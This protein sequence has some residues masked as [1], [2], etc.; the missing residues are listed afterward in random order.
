MTIDE[1]RRELVRVAQQ[2]TLPAVVE[3]F[4]L[5]YTEQGGGVL[6]FV[7]G[8]TENTNKH[9]RNPVRFQGISYQPLPIEV[10]GFAL[11]SKGELPRPTL[12]VSNVPFV[13]VSGQGEPV[14]AR[15]FTSLVLNF[16][17]LVGAKLIRRRTF[18]PY[19]DTQPTA[20][21]NI[22]F[23]EDVYFVEQKTV[24]NRNIVEFE[25]VTSLDLDGVQLPRRQVTANLCVWGYRHEEC[26]FAENRVVATEDN[27][28]IGSVQRYRG[29]WNSTLVFAANDGVGF[30]AGDGIFRVYRAIQSNVTGAGQ[31]PT[32]TAYWVVDQVF[33]GEFSFETEYSSKDVVFVSGIKGRRLFRYRD[34]TA[35]TTGI[36]PPNTV[37]WEA[38]VCGKLLT[39]SC[40][41]RFDP[42]N[43]GTV[44]PFG[45]FPGTAKLPEV[46]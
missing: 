27:V 45:G 46:R 37:Y 12:R 2:L 4:V 29:I 13:G 10:R 7:S 6:Y 26:G 44:L 15:L 5:D 25:L 21:P 33:R 35:S 22:A 43:Q 42:A 16:D 24:E 20:D 17:D 8:T 41:L 11:K 23:P 19:L 38:D 36:R 3:M 31:S 30:T 39:T 9:P 18:F 28:K 32:N 14:L 34:L 40:K 1:G